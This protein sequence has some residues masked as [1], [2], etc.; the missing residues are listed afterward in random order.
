MGIL[1]TYNYAESIISVA[2]RVSLHCV[3]FVDW[4]FPGILRAYVICRVGLYNKINVEKTRQC[5]FSRLFAIKKSDSVPETAT[6]LQGRAA[7]APWKNFSKK[8][9]NFE[10]RICPNP[11]IFFVIM[12][13]KNDSRKS[14]RIIRILK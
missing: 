13:L 7:Y 3:I 14:T 8:T 4:N 2:L 5:I 6:K 10:S 9:W 12:L 1:K 11:V